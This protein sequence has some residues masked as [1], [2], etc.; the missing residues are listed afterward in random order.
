[1]HNTKH[2]WPT[3]LLAVLHVF[4]EAVDVGTAHLAPKRATVSWGGDAGYNTK[5]ERRSVSLPREEDAVN[6]DRFAAIR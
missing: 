6:H 2:C 4:G 1:M 3:H 5:E